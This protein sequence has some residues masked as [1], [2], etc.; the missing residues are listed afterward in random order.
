[1]K[2]EALLSS[3]EKRERRR[4]V[5]KARTISPPSPRVL[6]LHGAVAGPCLT[7]I[8]L[9]VPFLGQ[10]IAVLTVL[11]MVRLFWVSRSLRSVGWWCI[12]AAFTLA[13]VGAGISFAQTTVEFWL[14]IL[15]GGSMAGAVGTFIGAGALLSDQ[16]E[17][18]RI[19]CEG[20]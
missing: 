9:F 16:L 7:S 12:G 19:A 2:T 6:L 4:I 14:Y 13:A 18:A 15:F 3:I 10:T 17:R 8:F 11:L 20:D 1:M 5:S